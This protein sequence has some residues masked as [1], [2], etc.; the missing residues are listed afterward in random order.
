MENFKGL[1]MTKFLVKD[2]KNL[3]ENYCKGI[4]LLYITDS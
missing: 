1:E 4:G 2:F 3:L